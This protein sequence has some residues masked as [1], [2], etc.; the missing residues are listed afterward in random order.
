MKSAMSPLCV[1][2]VPATAS[3]GTLLSPCARRLRA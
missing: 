1:S 2:S 3:G